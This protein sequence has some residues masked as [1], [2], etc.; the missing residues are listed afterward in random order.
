M[1]NFNEFERVILTHQDQL[2]KFAF[3]KTGSMEDAQDIVQNV[4]IRL[5]NEKFD[6]STIENLKAYLF[7]CVSNSCN[8]LLR[9]RK[10]HRFISAENMQLQSL[11]DYDSESEREYNRI[12]R[13]MEDIPSE[14][15]D[16]IKMRIINNLTFNEIANILGLPT[17]TVKSRFKY[18]IDKLRVKINFNN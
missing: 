5:F 16:V 17:T 2:L 13:L 14:Q 9:S 8:D 10:R 6:F 7:R 18:G 4:F 1:E 11:P 15:A 12:E 3:F